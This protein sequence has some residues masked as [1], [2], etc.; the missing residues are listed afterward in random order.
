MKKNF[1]QLK[2]IST[3][4]FL[5]S[6]LL[7]ANCNE[8]FAI[9]STIFVHN[10]LNK[11]LPIPQYQNK[12][13]TFLVDMSNVSI[14]L[15]EFS[16]NLNNYFGLD[17][18][19]KF[20][21]VNERY[22]SETGFTHSSYQHF[23][24][25]VKVHGDLI[26]I[27]SK[28][29]KIKYVDG[30]LINVKDLSIF[31]TISDEKVKS[32]AYQE[33]G[34]EGNV[35][36]GIIETYIFKQETQEQ[37]LIVKL[38]NKINLTALYPL[39]S[40]DYIID[41]NSGAL[42]SQ[43]SKVYKVDTPSASATYYRGNKGITV[44]SYNGNYRLM[45]NA[46]KIRTLNGSQLNGN[47]RNDG[48]FSGFSEYTNTSANFTSTNSKPAVE[49]HWAMR[50]TYD[51]YKNIHNRTSF[52]G[53]SHSIN[54][55]YN[56]GNVLGDH[57]NAAA[58][59]EMVGNDLYNGMFY[60]R[61]GSRMNPVVSLDIAGHEYSHMVVSRNG[62]GGLDYQGESGALNESF[63]DIFG[64]AIEFYV[65]EN[66]NW[67]MGEGVFKNN[68]TPDY[69]RSMSDPKNTP[70]SVGAPQQPNTY[71]GNYWASTTSSFDNGGV[72]IN[73]GVGNH[74]F[75]LLSVGGTG[76]ND[77]GK[78]Y[79]VNGISI[80]KAE[81]IAYKALTSGLTPTATYLDAYNATINA[82]ITLYG[83]NSN[84]WEQVVNAWYAVGI[85]DA[86]ASTK[87]YEM[88]S[89]LKVYPNPVTSDYV[90]IESTLDSVTTVEMFD[91]T[92]KKVLAP[93]LL[94]NQTTINVSGYQTGMYILKFKSS[95]GEYSHKLM[96]K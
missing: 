68:V 29:E 92:G 95:L 86:P 63:A 38:V 75:Y 22:D 10:T 64:T 84:E 12:L 30:Q 52:D 11:E 18:Y 79:Y 48:T 21:L 87:N 13:G 31:E 5:T 76:V 16:N 82:A 53:N 46:R 26:F 9:N 15:N 54:N 88:Q 2:K 96:I 89:K 42:I 39:M 4:L 83:S 14:S 33:F 80:N 49:V 59:D 43:Q 62:N 74:W 17:Q 77:L 55:Y 47:L 45:D 57:E 7:V 69:F 20:V 65:N 56:A 90:T 24:K 41:A 70:V 50:Q 8:G 6:F 93:T 23:Y 1:F 25:D 73:S 78:N 72:H 40:I 51:Y 81:K 71:K 34:R 28:E 91:L 44:D 85:G 32:L 35:K 36:E 94:Q 60:G 58:V 19:H 37:G 61:G 67:T 27:H 3:H 66:P